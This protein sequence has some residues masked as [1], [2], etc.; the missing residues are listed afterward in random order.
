MR[1]IPA[2]RFKQTCLQLLD[3][4]EE[5]GEVIVVTK[6]GRAVAQLVPL[7]AASAGAWLGSM[8]GIG[9]V[10]ELEDYTRDREDLGG[11]GGHWG[12]ENTVG[13]PRAALGGGSLGRCSA[14]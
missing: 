7:P 8:S 5:S 11:I 1:T 12:A 14:G 4:V 6:R 10:G 2:G 3:E 13:H 9:T